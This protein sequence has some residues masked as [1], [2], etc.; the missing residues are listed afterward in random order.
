M[1]RIVKKKT[2]HSFLL[3][4]ILL[5]QRLRL[6]PKFILVSALFVLPLALLTVLLFVE[7]NKSIDDAYQERRGLVTVRQ[8]T[9]IKQLLQQHRALRHMALAGNTDADERAARARG[10][11]TRQLAALGGL[12]FAEHNAVTT[13]AHVRR[14]WTEIEAGMATTKQKDSYAAHSRIIALLTALTSSVADQ[15]RLTLDPDANGSRLASTVVGTLPLVADNL[16]EIAGRGASYI[17]TGLLEANEDLLL[18]SSLMVARRDVARVPVQLEAEFGQNPL[19]Q[20][21]LEGNMVA[22]QAAQS[23]L[24]R[25]RNEVLNSLDQTSGSQFFQAGQTSIEALS[26]LSNTAADALD[27]LLEERIAR[28]ILRR[29]LL[30]LVVLASLAFAAYLL[31]G[32]YVSFSREL[33][34]LE[35]AVARAKSGDLAT[36]VSSDADD[37]IGNLVNTFASMNAGLVHLVQVV[38]ES[39]DAITRTSRELANDSTNLS[40]RTESQASSLAGC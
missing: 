17:D 25:A 28:K 18:H 13:L 1:V 23:F 11:I 22:V 32:F 26:A 8:I 29:N 38:R 4:A 33:R 9:D 34:K 35:N 14:G 31:C 27:T 3:P 37:E 19:L 40:A 15:S 10:D 24:D 5:M 36:K 20:K 7:L 16:F 21:K 39:S 30:A 6:L 12:F 2:V